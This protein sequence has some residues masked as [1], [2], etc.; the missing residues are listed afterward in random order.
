MLV[1]NCGL[2]EKD[3]RS[4]PTSTHKDAQSKD[5][6]CFKFV[7]QHLP[8][9]HATGLANLNTSIPQIHNYS[10]STTLISLSPYLKTIIK[11]QTSVS[12][13]CTNM[14]VFITPKSKLPCCSKGLSK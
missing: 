6:S 14:K 11:Y 7:T 12:I 8:Y 9:V 13:Q 4:S 1:S 3:H 5:T 10:T 2:V